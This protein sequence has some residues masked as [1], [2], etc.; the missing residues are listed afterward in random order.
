MYVGNGG[1]ESH[2]PDGTHLSDAS[3]DNAPKR[4][5]FQTADDQAYAWV[6]QMRQYARPDAQLTEGYICT[7]SMMEL[8]LRDGRWQPGP[9]QRD[10]DACLVDIKQRGD[11]HIF[12]VLHRAGVSK[13]ALAEFNPVTQTWTIKSDFPNLFWPLPSNTSLRFWLGKQTIVV[14]VSATHVQPRWLAP[15]RKT[16]GIK[17]AQEF[18]YSVD[19]GRSWTQLSRVPILGLGKTSDRLFGVRD[20]TV[21]VFDLPH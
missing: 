14:G 21:Y 7:S 1:F 2:L 9:V 20:K 17:F 11:G 6:R 3:Y 8:R 18:F 4:F 10:F 16:I 5:I 12:G 13:D 19:D 15:W